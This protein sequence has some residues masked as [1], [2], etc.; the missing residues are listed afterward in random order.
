ME[1]G[2]V[3]NKIVAVLLILTFFLLPSS[4]SASIFC[5]Y[6]TKSYLKKMA[7]NINLSYDYVEQE[8]KAIFK[9]TFSNVY[10]EFYLKEVK[11]GQVYYPDT[12]KDL[13]EIEVNNYNSGKSYQFEVYTNR[14]DCEDEILA[15][16]YASLPYYNPY[17]KEDV[18]TNLNY[19]LCSKWSQHN[20][21]KEQFIEN[22]TKYKESLK[23]EE[24]EIPL[25]EENKL[26]YLL[27]FYLNYYYIILPIIIIGLSYIIY[28][29]NKKD[30]FF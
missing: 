11:T 25:E 1:D 12:T 7:S 16:F 14:V 23:Q 2:N 18:C 4:I 19:E 28:L 5:T 20:L 26:P 27:E 8:E 24:I 29:H 6:D 9:I 17:Y 22:V 30:S 21:S 3:K 10:K 13:S 15:T